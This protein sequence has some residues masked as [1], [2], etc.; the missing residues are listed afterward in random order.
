M[1][2]VTLSLLCVTMFGSSGAFAQ[3]AQPAANLQDGRQVNQVAP[4]SHEQVY[5]ELVSSRNDGSLYRV[6]KLYAHH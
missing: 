2:K 3:T 1:K 6:N 4:L 5:Q